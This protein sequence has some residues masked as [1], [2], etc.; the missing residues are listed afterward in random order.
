MVKLLVSKK[1][2][3]QQ[4]ENR[5]YNEQSNVD[6]ETSQ[7]QCKK[8]K[9]IS[10]LSGLEVGFFLFAYIIKRHGVYAASVEQNI[11]PPVTAEG[12]IYMHLLFI[13]TSNPPAKDHT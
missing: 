10:D 5:K 9:P 7:F 3:N 11:G 12:P 13:F 8:K 1:L 4:F 6:A 2:A